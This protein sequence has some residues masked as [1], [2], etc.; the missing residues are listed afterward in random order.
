M[1]KVKDVIGKKD[2]AGGA[3]KDALN[4]AGKSGKSLKSLKIK[5]KFK[6]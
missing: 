4:V 3:V 6:G 2:S 5:L 1:K